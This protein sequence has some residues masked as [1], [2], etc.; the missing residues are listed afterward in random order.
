MGVTRVHE[1]PR[2]TTMPEERPVEKAASMGCRARY[3]AGTSNVSNM[4]SA[5]FSRCAITLDGGSLSTTGCS[6]VSQCMLEKPYCHSASIMSQS[7]YSP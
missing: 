1:C 5:I 7:S 2:S 4:S 6:L 3:S